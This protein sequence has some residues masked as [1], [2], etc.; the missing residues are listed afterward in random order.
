[1]G[2]SI[3]YT[4][5][6]A[7]P[8]LSQQHCVAS[9]RRSFVFLIWGRFHEAVR[10]LLLPCRTLWSRSDVW[11]SRSAAMLPQANICRSPQCQQGSCQAT[12]ALWPFLFLLWQTLHIITGSL[13]IEK[14]YSSVTCST[15]STRDLWPL[16]RRDDVPSGKMSRAALQICQ[17]WI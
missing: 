16:C 6:T 9:H 14:N 2:A 5:R 17:Q 15:S 3:F 8:P 13:G 7:T 11:C 4:C 10:R 12:F 1:M